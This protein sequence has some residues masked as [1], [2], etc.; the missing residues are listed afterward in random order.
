MNN[1]SD[2]QLP[3]SQNMMRLHKF[4]SRCGV[5]SR[6]ASE[7]LIASGHVCVDGQVIT[8]MG[9][10]VDPA[11][12]VVELDGVR[13]TLPEAQTTIMLYKPAGYVSTMDDP[14]G[15]S[16]VAELVPLQE[17]PSLFPIGRLD[18]D[19][20]GLYLF[21]TDGDLGNTLLRPAHHV[22]KEYFVACMGKISKACFQKLEEGIVL[23][24]KKTLPAKVRQF[25]VEELKKAKEILEPS[26]HATLSRLSL[27]KARHAQESVTYFSITITEGRNRQIRNMCASI[28][29]PV[30]G[31]HRA[32]MGN[33]TLG[34]LQYGKCRTLSA[35][36]VASLCC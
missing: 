28:S 4:L 9:S 23:D 2:T 14:Q 17:H 20:T 32:R 7:E 36:E 12:N 8:E 16:T 31:L 25:S 1:Q 21:S 10:K 6:R 22:E 24:G 30:L 5:A 26:M 15:R 27:A 3:Q 34:N 29:H 33:L 13:L 18:F 11:I 35:E 19:T